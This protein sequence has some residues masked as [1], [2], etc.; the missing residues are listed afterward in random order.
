MTEAVFSVQQLSERW[1]FHPNTIRR[2]EEEGK[3][4]RLTGLPQVRYSAKEV[5]QLESVGLDAK[6]L[7]P[8]ERRQKDERIRELEAIVQGL[9]DRLCKIQQL[10]I[11]SAK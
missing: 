3:L 8:W 2:M 7:S 10:A 5:M 11:G 1:N 9:E 4:H 6:A